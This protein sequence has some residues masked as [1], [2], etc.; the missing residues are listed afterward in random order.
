MPALFIFLL[1]V[2]IALLLCCAGYYLVLR[3]L[4]F[5][6]LNRV[7]LV[8]AILFASIYPQI[9]LSGF[10]QRHQEFTKPVQAVVI[11]WRAP[12][13]ALIKPFTEPDYWHWME[14]IFWTG[15]ALLALRL[16]S[17]L[18]SLFKL[19]RN[20]V[21]AQIHNHRVRIL[22]GEN[23]PFSF[24]KSIYINPNK[25]K[26]AD[27][28]AILLHEQVHVNEWHT[29]DIL[30]AELSTIFYWFN[31]GVWLM[32]KA[33]RENIEFIT[34]RKI[35]NGGVDAKQYQYSLV[36]V[37]FAASPQ[38][39]V[40]HFNISTIKKRII[41]MNAKRSSK[42]NLTRY[43]FLVPA[44]VVLLLIFSISRAALVKKNA[45]LFKIETPK[46][47]SKKIQAQIV[48]EI[49]VQTSAKAKQIDLPAPTSV[50]DTIKTDNV[51]IKTSGSS[52]SLNYIINGVKATKAEFKALDPDH[53][54]AVEVVSAERAKKI[55]DQLNNN[56]SVLFVTT[57][58]SESGKKF[59]EKI[60]ELNDNSYTL[61]SKVST[62]NSEPATMALAGKAEALSL[63]LPRA[64]YRI[65]ARKK[66][67]TLTKA[68]DKWVITEN[69]EP[70]I[71][72]E[73]ADST[74][75]HAKALKNILKTYTLNSHLKKGKFD[76][77]FYATP[78][79]GLTYTPKALVAGKWNF[80]NETN[81]RH[82]S[83]KM[84]MIDGKEASESDLKKLSAANIESMSVKLG[85]EV[86]KQYGEK[87][88]NGIVFIETK[89]ASH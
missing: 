29:V 51:L 37:S 85:D 21:P 46:I 24:W 20:S 7:Y 64:R 31:P 30:L 11:N 35:L 89:K 19:Y 86:T 78:R 49:P 82:L 32:K 59:K 58:D 88:R 16:L 14:V 55:F 39:L 42:F 34:D 79:H 66:A 45:P 44:V 3:H 70:L 38:T 27:L 68:G 12:A 54:Y 33:V 43:A 4:T 40:N 74:Y 65:D 48:A 60:D 73:F 9:N 13:N 52:D 15:A 63:T 72:Q 75:V 28:K 17:Q 77:M 84:I 23:G 76:T 8:A 57:D 87:A 80:N 6:T 1:K 71:V 50:G 53:I 36:N 5:Y 26:A 81:I 18:Y 67:H 56:H 2:N 22:D 61:A 83:S 10:V 62:W 47:P 25:Y 41:M 69:N